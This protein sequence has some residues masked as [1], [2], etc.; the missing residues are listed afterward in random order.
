MDLLETVDF[1]KQHFLRRMAKLYIQQ[2]PKYEQY[3]LQIDVAAVL[4]NQVDNS[5]LSVKIVEN[6]I[7]DT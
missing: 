2:N 6:A 4:M 3:N 1:R 5:V 7:E